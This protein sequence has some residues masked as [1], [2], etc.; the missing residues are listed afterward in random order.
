M[1]RRRTVLAAGAVALAGCQPAREIAGGFNGPSPERGHL[2]REA[3]VAAAPAVT[4]RCGVLVAGGGIAGLSAARTL[5]LAGVEDFAVLE[6][7]DEAGGNSR[8]AR[9]GGLACPLGAHY[10]PVPGDGAHEVRDF[11]EEIGLAKR[12][13]GRWVYEERH[14]CHSPQERLFFNGQW[15]E[16]LLPLQGVGPDTL[17]Q[18]R[19]FALRVAQAQARDRFLLPLRGPAPASH[20]ALDAI[21]FAA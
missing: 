15:Q 9:V 7:E 14:L 2:L 16:G 1:M 3:R 6:L 11:L 12:A 13:F 8:G 5:R 18:Y 20:R 17:A 10:L 4:R 21:T 19:L